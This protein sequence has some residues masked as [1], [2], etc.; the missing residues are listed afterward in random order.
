MWGERRASTYR[1]AVRGAF[2]CSVVLKDL[3]DLFIPRSAPDP[4]VEEVSVEPTN[5][6]NANCV[7]CGYQFQERPHAQIPL[8]T[9]KQIADATARAG[10]TRLRF[11]PSVGEPLVHRG[12][13][14]LVAAARS[15]SPPLRVGLTTNGILL[16]PERY[17]RLVDAGLASIIVSMT[18]PDAAEYERIF[19]NANYAKLIRNLES[20]LDAYVPGECEITLSVRTSR[21]GWKRHP[22]FRRARKAGWL[23]TRNVFYDDWSGK[24]SAL[25]AEHELA[26]RPLR[27]QRLP[28]TWIKSGPHFLVDGRATACGCRDLHGDA[29]AI[30]P[31]ALTDLRQSYRDGAGAAH[32]N[33]FRDGTAHEICVTCRHYTPDPRGEPLRLRLAQLV[34][35]ATSAVK[36]GS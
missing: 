25:L 8:A 26:A 2:W 23:L 31:E 15:T 7:F 16:T 20:I 27:T 28:C 19:R 29:L 24:V 17:R 10:A 30:G 1:L 4:L 9:V 32:I 6:C 34:A 22:L 12:L 36:L 5:L 3:R 35:D 21:F 33:A 14:D 18:Y 11:T 13:E